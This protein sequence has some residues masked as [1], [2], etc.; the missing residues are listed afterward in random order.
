ME[1]TAHEGAQSTRLQTDDTSARGAALAVLP[2]INLDNDPAHDCVVAGMM[3]ELVT[4]LTRIRSLSVI[5]SGSTIALAGEALPPQAV[6]ERLG[7]RYLLEGSVRRTGT[8]VR[9]SVRLTD[10]VVNTQLWA[11]RFDGVLEDMFAL[12]DDVAL[13]IAGVIEP[14]VRAAET[15]RAA[16]APL[17][18]LGSYD[19]YLRAAQLRMSL[20]REHVTQA[21]ALLERA[22]A[23]DPD[24]AAALAQAAGCHSLICINGWSDDLASHRQQGLALVDRALRTCDDDAS[25]LAQLANALMDLEPKPGAN[26]DRALALIARATALNPALAFA[27]FIGGVLN[28]I[29]GNGPAAEEHLQRAMQLDPVSQLHETARAHLGLALAVQGRHAE[30]AAELRTASN[31]PPRGRLALAYLHSELGEMQEAREELR[32]YRQLTA[33]PTETMVASMCRCAELRTVMSAA[34]GRI[35]AGGDDALT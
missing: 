14:K 12:Q 25:V 35:H 10:A 15:R 22:L 20:S 23:Q 3:E 21:L 17:Q 26:I 18:N 29:D 4:A 1:V 27:W 6:A 19:L 13:Q 24:F 9:I 8:R 30:A 7:V 31:L 33:I 34:L 16:R 28:L 5:A 32:R 11:Q 2:F